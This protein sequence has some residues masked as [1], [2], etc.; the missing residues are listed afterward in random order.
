MEDHKYPHST[1]T[2]PSG[3]VGRAQVCR[4]NTG[5]TYP[6]MQMRVAKSR[7]LQGAV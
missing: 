4:Y 1:D 3:G 2:A 6:V 5:L 7:R